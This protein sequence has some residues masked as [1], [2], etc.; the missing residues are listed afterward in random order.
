MINQ[1]CVLVINQYKFYIEKGESITDQ[2]DGL[3]FVFSIV[4]PNF[5]LGQVHALVRSIE[6]EYLM[7]CCL[8]FEASAFLEYVF[9]SGICFAKV[10]T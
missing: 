5:F 8:L 10:S 3:I 4:Q 6:P 7:D 2:S 1:P 9:F